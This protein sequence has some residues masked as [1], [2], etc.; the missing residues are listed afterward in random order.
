MPHITDRHGNADQNPSDS[1]SHPPGRL[2]SN[3][4]TGARNVQDVRKSEPSRIAGG[5]GKG[6]GHRGKIWWFFKRLNFEFPHN[7]ALPLLGVY[8]REMT[9]SVHTKTCPH[10]FAATLSVIGKK[11]KPPSVHQ[12]T[13][14]DTRNTLRPYNETSLSQEEERGACTSYHMDGP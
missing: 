10:V 11:W 14:T 6:G 8:P 7:P 2:E 12:H 4:H 3:K 1:T 5:K 13:Q 9:T